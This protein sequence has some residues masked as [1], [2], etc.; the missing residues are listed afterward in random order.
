MAGKTFMNVTPTADLENLLL[1]FC[2]KSL[3]STTDL[4]TSKPHSK[5]T[6]GIV[7]GYSKHTTAT[8]QLYVDGTTTTGDTV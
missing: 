1:L 7:C 2:W 3:R 8:K 6:E 5:A 4:Q